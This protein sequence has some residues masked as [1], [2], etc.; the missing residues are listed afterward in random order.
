[1]GRVRVSEPLREGERRGGRKGAR[2]GE[3]HKVDFHVS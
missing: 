3:R 2:R 1:M